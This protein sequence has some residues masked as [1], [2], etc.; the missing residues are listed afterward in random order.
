MIA[1]KKPQTVGPSILFLRKM[2]IKSFPTWSALTESPVRAD[3]SSPGS[4]S[5][6]A[7]PW[8]KSYKNLSADS[9][10]ARSAKLICGHEIRI[11]NLIRKGSNHA[12]PKSTVDLGHE[13]LIRVDHTL[14]SPL[15]PTCYRPII[16]LENKGIKPKSNRH[17][18]KNCQVAGQNWPQR[19]RFS[20]VLIRVHP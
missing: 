17:K 5:L 2:E 8:V 3:D 19:S 14:I 20:S 13:P 16:R 9:E 7:Q 11:Q 12:H 6:R 18:P 4:A 1:I 15:S 10:A